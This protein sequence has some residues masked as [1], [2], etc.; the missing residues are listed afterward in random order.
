MTT[1]WQAHPVRLDE[2]LAVRETY[3]LERRVAG[4]RAQARYALAV[5]VMGVLLFAY[6]LATQ[7]KNIITS[8]GPGEALQT[9][10][11]TFARIAATGYVVLF[12]ALLADFAP[13]VAGP[14]SV[15]IVLG[16][17]ITPQGQAALNRLPIGNTATKNTVVT[18]PN[19]PQNS[20]NAAQ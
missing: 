7:G 1:R 9:T 15:L 11:N 18:K 3:R 2:R 8:T 20:A 17:I 12:L 4:L 13:Q 16:L 14:M 19:A 6:V 10:G 5:L